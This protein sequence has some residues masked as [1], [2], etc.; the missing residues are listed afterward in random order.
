[1][2]YM[3]SH[4]IADSFFWSLNPDSLDTGGLLKK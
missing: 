2:D 3:V 4:C 1:V